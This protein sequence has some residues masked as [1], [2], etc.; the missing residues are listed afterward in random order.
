MKTNN[1]SFRKIYK[2]KQGKLPS[3]HKKINSL[4]NQI[5][6]EYK[7]E[8]NVYNL[9]IAGIKLTQMLG[10][11]D[12]ENW[13]FLELIG[14]E[15]NHKLPDYR[16]ISPEIKVFNPYKGWEE[17]YIYDQNIADSLKY[18]S[19]DLPLPNI[20]DL[21]KN[22]NQ[23]IEFIFCREVENILYDYVNYDFSDFKISC[24]FNT[25]DFEKILNLTKNNILDF[26]IELQKRDFESINQNQSDFVINKRINH[27]FNNNNLPKYKIFNNLVEED[28]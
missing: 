13:L 17:L 18:C 15:N 10:F 11:K 7:N 6:N 20:L 23:S 16:K 9:L 25:S 27:Y 22:N 14:Y 3:S 24:I 12:I 26:T 21:L 8:E 28:K 19:I 4:I 2:R 1:Y 5:Q